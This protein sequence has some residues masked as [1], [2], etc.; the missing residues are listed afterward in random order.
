MDVYKFKNS[1]KERLA[2]IRAIM[3]GMR[4]SACPYTV[5]CGCVKKTQ[6][7]K[8][9]KAGLQFKSFKL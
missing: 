9:E 6:M 3:Q 7:P 4:D 2:I 5:V 8:G 1:I